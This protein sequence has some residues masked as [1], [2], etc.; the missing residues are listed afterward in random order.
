MS[1]TSFA[2]YDG[3]AD[4]YEEYNAPAA[5]ANEAAISELLGP[6]G[7]LCLDLGCGG[8]QYFETIK[9]TGRDVIGLDYSADQLRIAR[10]R[11]AELLVRADA[12]TLPFA[13]ASFSTV[14]ALWV[15][16]DVDDFTAVLK[17]AA[18]V[19]APGGLLAYYGVHPCFNGPHVQARDDGARIVHPTYRAAGWH[20]D[21][22]WWGNNIRRRVGMRHLTLPDLLNAVL[23]AGLTISRV[24][25]PRTEPVPWILAI[26][27]HRHHTS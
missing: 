18:R 27:A 3:L 25:E 2:R 6:G 15:S 21:A 13:D 23:D 7:G 16:S 17:E 19:L 9:S 22:P 24:T 1:E 20:Q 14:T 4:W 11:D 5:A 26:R 8:G 10:N 12:A